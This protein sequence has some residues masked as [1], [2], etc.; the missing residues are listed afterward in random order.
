[1]SAADPIASVLIVDDS[2]VQRSHGAHLCRQ[3]GVAQIHETSNGQEALSLL[4]ALPQLPDLMI[5]DLEMPTMDG[6]ELLLQLHQRGIDIPIIVVS[7]RER[8][9]IES[10]QQMGGFLGLRVQSTLQKPLQMDSL[11]GALEHVGR[12]AAHQAIDKTWAIDAQALRSALERGDIDVHYQPKADVRTGI[13]RGAEALARWKHCDL[14]FVPPDQFIRLAERNELIHPLTIEV[15]NKAMLQA[16]AWQARGMHLPLAINLSPLLLESVELPNEIASLAQCHSLPP[17]R[18]VLE[19]TESSLVSQPGVALSVLA[20]L[21]LKGFGLSIDDYGTGFSSMSQ[22]A[23]IPFTELKIDRSFVRDAPQRE[24]LQVIL[25]S[26]IDMA[27]R[28]GLTSVAEGVE[29]LDEWRMLQEFGCTLGQGWL[30]GKAMPGDALV[31]WSK[32]H[33]AR[34]GELRA[35]GDG[36]VQAAGKR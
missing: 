12:E 1:M 8:A 11:R 18:I 20:R 3:L 16:A 19:I 26:A 7:S 34:L 15:M 17:E 2:G 28:L 27:N 5:V 29:T 14:G 23:R 24:S 22:L 30:I 21:R 36:E 33:R 4:A 31:A 35:A 6:P 32:Q 25:R 10:V 13:I 9:L